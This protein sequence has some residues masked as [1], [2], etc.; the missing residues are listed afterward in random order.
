M[1]RARPK[2]T[3]GEPMKCHYCKKSG[4]MQKECYKQIKENGAMITA[5]GKQYE[6]NEITEKTV[7]T[8][9]ASGYLPLNSVGHTVVPSTVLDISDVQTTPQLINNIRNDVCDQVEYKINSLHSRPFINCRIENLLTVRALYDTGADVNC[10]SAIAFKKIPLKSRPIKLPDTHSALGSANNEAMKVLGRY[11]M[12]IY[13]AGKDVK[14]TVLIADGLNEE[15]IISMTL[16][17]PH[18]LYW[19]PDSREMG[20]RTPMAQRPRQNKSYSEAC[21]IDPHHSSGTDE[22][23]M[24]IGAQFRYRLYHKH[25]P[26]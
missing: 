25:W 12:N 14:A 16:I 4:H 5:Q 23:Q 11:S 2:T 15:F 8:I 13:V 6:A 20:K 7:G 19:N 26:H 18:R 24:W 1:E 3:N 9:T 21:R 10:M 17:G 22:H